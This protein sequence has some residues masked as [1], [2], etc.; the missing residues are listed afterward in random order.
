MMTRTAASVARRAARTAKTDLVFARDSRL[1]TRHGGRGFTLIEL[2]VVIL[3]ILI[4]SAVALPTVLPAINHRQVSEA[5]RLLQGG[6]AGA[7]DNAI[8]ENQP[9][10]IRLLPDPT[11]PITWVTNAAGVPSINPNTILAYNRF[12]PIEAAPEYNEGMVS[13]Y[14]THTYPSGLLVAGLTAGGAPCLVL[15]EAVTTS[16]G[17]PN[18][19]TSWF[20]NIR[21]GDKVQV[22]GAGPWYTVAGPMVTGAAGGNSELFVNVGAPGTQSPFQRGNFFPDFLLLVNGRDDNNNGW[23]DEGFDGVDNNGN[24][25]TDEL[26][27][28]EAEAWHGAAANGMVSVT[29]SIQRRPAPSANAREVALPTSMVIDATTVFLTQERSRFP[30]GAVNP[31][32]GYIDIVLNPD[33]TVLPTVIYSSPSSFNMGSTFYHFWLAER[34][35]L[36][37]VP[38]D[39]NGNP[40]PLPLATGAP[41]YLP[42]AQPGGAG[43]GL[44]P[45]PYLKGDYSVLTL[46]TRTGQISANANPP[47][48]LDPAVGYTNQPGSTATYNPIYPFIQAEQGVNGEH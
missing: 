7:R 44:F 34:Q 37:D 21:V 16:K 38:T 48:F 30:L 12:V 15:E 3:I 5:A 10:G 24:G 1:A 27:E 28:W 18:S 20:W 35:D 22:N 33:G 39:S 17:M 45:G 6:L 11:Y 36:A 4:I 14:P 41:Y 9:N 13:I 31:Y 8:R 26:A 42:I 25:V 23:I 46:F 43:A 47:F 40:L 32:T 19:P 29:Y 2:L